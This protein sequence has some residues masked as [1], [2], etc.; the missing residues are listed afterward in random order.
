MLGP[1]KR[2]LLECSTTQKQ[3]R[4]CKD[5]IC[6][7]LNITHRKEK[8]DP[9]THP[10]SPKSPRLLSIMGKRKWTE[11]W[12]SVGRDADSNVLSHNHLQP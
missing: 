12:G 1:L 6:Q 7:N 9:S 4:L 10:A 2:I 3:I 8:P 11:K 5:G